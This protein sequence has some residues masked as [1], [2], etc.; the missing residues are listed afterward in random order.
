MRMVRVR[1][2]CSETVVGLDRASY[3]FFKQPE[4]GINLP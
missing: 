4:V 1:A 2:K 3:G